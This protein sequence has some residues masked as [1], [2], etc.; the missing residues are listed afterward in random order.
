MDGSEQACG[1]A[2]CKSSLTLF[3][4]SQSSSLTVNSAA[5]FLLPP[6]SSH[7]FTHLQTG[8]SH[9]RSATYF[10]IP[11]TNTVSVAFSGIS[12]ADQ[13]RKQVDLTA[14]LHF[15]TAPRIP[16]HPSLS[17]IYSRTPA[18]VSLFL[19]LPSPG[20]SPKYFLTSSS[21]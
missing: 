15:S 12:Q 4:Q 3:F 11:A 16:V 5:D 10:F 7:S 6:P 17:Q 2:D 13:T 8:P 14:D 20:Y 19:L 9:C 18:T 21:H 1:E